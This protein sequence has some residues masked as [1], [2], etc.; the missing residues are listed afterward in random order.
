MLGDVRGAISGLTGSFMNTEWWKGKGSVI[1]ERFCSVKRFLNKEKMI[2][3]NGYTGFVAYFL[4]GPRIVSS[5]V[6]MRVYGR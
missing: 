4:N 1:S 5:F 3:R 6:K 2:E